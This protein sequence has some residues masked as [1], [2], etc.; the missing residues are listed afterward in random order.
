MADI[1]D[2]QIKEI[3][4]DDV[5]LRTKLVSLLCTDLNFQ[6][7]TSN[8]SSHN[9]HS[10]PAKFPPQFP[11]IFIEGLT[12][13]GDVILDPMMGSGTTIVEAWLANKQVIGLDIDPLALLVSAVKVTPLDRDK[14]EK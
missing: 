3:D 4:S 9:F 5:S 13:P 1:T 14:I 2:S 10:F 12:N 8:Y 7:Q 11:R 6:G